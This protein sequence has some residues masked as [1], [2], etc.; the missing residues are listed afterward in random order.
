MFG[1]YAVYIGGAAWL[2]ISS[3]L[4]GISQSWLMLVVFRA[5]QGLGLAAFLPSGVMILGKTYRPGPR[6]NFVFSLYGACA[7]LGFF[8]GIFFSG[9]CSQY[10][11]WRWYFFIGAIL[12]A[13]TTLSSI[14]FVPR[15]YK[16][17]RKQGAQMDWAGCVLSVSGTVLFVFAI[18]YSS[19]APDG[20]RTPYIPVCFIL[21]ALFIIAMVYVEGWV[22]KNPLLPGDIFA[23][24][25]MKPL[26][27]ALL[28]LYGSLGV[29]FL[30][31]VL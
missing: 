31:A 19:Y 30:Y 11:T 12:S 7:A 15:D 21:G 9:L 3:I 26:A 22:A 14:F 2:T 16:E 4:C 24:K 13:I 23:V 10:L 6:K 17:T 1:G 29:F 28:F 25:Y 27:I 8:V 20:W 5:L 18:A